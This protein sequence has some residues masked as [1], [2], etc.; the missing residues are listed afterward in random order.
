MSDDNEL[1]MVAGVPKKPET[2]ADASPEPEAEV[3][4]AEAEPT[5]PEVEESEADSPP[6]V[7]GSDDETES[8]DT[9]SNEQKRIA[10]LAFENRKLR[11]ELQ[12]KQSRA[13]A[14]A[15]PI[16][17]RT[18]FD[19]DEEFNEYLVDQGA[20]RAERRIESAREQQEFQ[21]NRDKLESDVEAF[22]ASNDL[23]GKMAEA[24]FAPDTPITQ[25][26][27]QHFEDAETDAELR[28]GVAKHL[29]V[30]KPKELSRIAGLSPVQ[31]SREMVKLETKIAKDIA[32]MKAEKSKTSKAPAPP[33]PVDGSD[34][35]VSDK[36]NPTSPESDQLSTKEWIARRNKQLYG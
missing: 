10:E 15:E 13:E 31:Q 34:P 12:A 25:V 32:K 35:G 1:S 3:V 7:E 36:A 27:A 14:E 16:K 6:A 26:V 20:Q 21:S 11:R 4:E 9:Q 22:D 8:D 33:K 23:D 18:E 24:M 2:G 17:A 29:L 30:D 5:E 19:T 28:M